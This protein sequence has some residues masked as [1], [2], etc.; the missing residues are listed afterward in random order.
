MRW[1]NGYLQCKSIASIP[2][3]VINLE[4]EMWNPTKDIRRAPL[5]TVERPAKS[6]DLVRGLRYRTRKMLEKLENR[7]GSQRLH[8][9]VRDTLASVAVAGILALPMVLDVFMRP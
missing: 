1:R 5:V 6:H 2:D 3:G 8:R 4:S 9:L 7:V